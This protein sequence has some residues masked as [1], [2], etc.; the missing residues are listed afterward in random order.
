MDPIGAAGGCGT[1][2]EKRDLRAG[3]AAAD[4]R[5]DVSVLPPFSARYLKCLITAD[6]VESTSP[7]KWNP[8]L[9]AAY[10]EES[11]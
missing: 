4:G 3:T 9:S 1:G 11:G 10:R 2:A 6:G 5:L 8:C 7:A